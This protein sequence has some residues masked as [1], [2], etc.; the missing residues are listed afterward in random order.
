[1]FTTRRF[2]FDK[3]SR[4]DHLIGACEVTLLALEWQ[5]RAKEVD[6]L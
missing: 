3:R 5:S 6:F 4:H 1:M 2:P